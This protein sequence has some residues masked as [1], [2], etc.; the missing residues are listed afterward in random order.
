MST[1]DNEPTPKDISGN[2][3]DKL[4]Q[5]ALDL[6]GKGYQNGTSYAAEISSRIRIVSVDLK[7][8]LITNEKQAVVVSEIEVA[9]GE[10]LISTLMVSNVNREGNNSILPPQTCVMYGQL[11]MEGALLPFWTG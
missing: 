2:A 10:L 4:K 6:R 3:S 7:P 11:C 8:M 1:R 9:E 5:A